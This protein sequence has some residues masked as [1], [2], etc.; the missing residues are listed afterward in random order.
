M[1]ATHTVAAVISVIA[2]VILII[3]NIINHNVLEKKKSQK[4][5][6]EELANWHEYKWSLDDRVILKGCW[7]FVGWYNTIQLIERI[8]IV[9]NH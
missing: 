4:L 9:I 5:K 8:K 3:N 2:V 1:Q 6:A 7:I